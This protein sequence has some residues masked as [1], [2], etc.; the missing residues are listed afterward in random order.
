MAMKQLAIYS[1]AD[2]FA[3]IAT[4]PI[5]SGRAKGPFLKISKLEDDTSYDPGIDGD[6]TINVN[7]NTY[8]EVSMLIMPQSP[9]NA[10]L[11]GVYKQGRILSRRYRPLIV[12]LSVIDRS[13]EGDI[14]VTP[15]AWLKK[16]PDQ[17]YADKKAPLEYVFGLHDPDRVIVGGGLV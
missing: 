16:L 6:G 15:Q 8:H 1:P 11:T 2:A 5:D 7:L 4:I 12:P 10:F 14:L 17:E 3:V 9:S 13:T